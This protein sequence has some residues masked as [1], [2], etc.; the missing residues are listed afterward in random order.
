[1]Y[2]NTFTQNVFFSV[3]QILC[4]VKTN[5]KSLQ[6]NLQVVK[7][8][9]K[10]KTK[11]NVKHMSHFWLIYLFCWKIQTMCMEETEDKNIRN[12]TSVRLL[13]RRYPITSHMLSRN[14]INQSMWHIAYLNDTHL[15]SKTLKNAFYKEKYF[16]VGYWN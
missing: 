8:K 1:M 16:V 6:I 11:S 2:Y 14:Y 15:K 7:K 4:N 13:I 12:V 10:M 9:K 5:T 3:L